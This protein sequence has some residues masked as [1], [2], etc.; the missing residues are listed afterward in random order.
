[1]TC[2][3]FSSL[4]G[5]LDEVYAEGM[6]N[7][8][9]RI[10]HWH[11]ALILYVYTHA[12][13]QLMSEIK[14]ITDCTMALVSRF[15]TCVAEPLLLQR[16]YL[17]YRSSGGCR[18][19]GIPTATITIMTLSFALSFNFQRSTIGN[20]CQLVVSAKTEIRQYLTVSESHAARRRLYR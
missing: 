5:G 2:G 15:A 10:V 1:M 3:I 13:R 18:A 11:S 7:C 14:Y 17:A 16:K 12:C 9:D 8:N 4:E 19:A 20:Y 6:S